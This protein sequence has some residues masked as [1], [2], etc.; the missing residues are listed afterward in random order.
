MTMMK[1]RQQPIGSTQGICRHTNKLTT[2]L[3]VEGIALEME[4]DTGAELSTIPAYIYQQN[5][6]KIKLCHPHLHQYDGSTIPVKGDIKV[7]ASTGEQSVAGSFEIVD[8]NNDQLPLLGRNWLLQLRL[9]WPKL[10]QYGSL[11][12]VQDKILQE[13]FPSV[14]KEKLGLLVGMEAN[15]E[16][17]EG[18]RPKF[19]RVTLFLL[20]YVRRL[21]KPFD[22]G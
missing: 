10:L 3:Q 9:D 5:L 16:L 17:K 4:V 20:L 11:Y 13:D 12:H 18:A 21:K 15:I 22:S 2:V 19:A 1:I 6:H 14:F 8:I 7:V